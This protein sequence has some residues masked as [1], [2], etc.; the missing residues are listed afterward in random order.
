MSALRDAGYAHVE[1]H[2]RDTMADLLTLASRASAIVVCTGGPAAFV[3][4]PARSTPG[5]VI[6]DVGVPA[7]VRSAQGFTRVTL[8]ELLARPRRLLDDETRAWL[9][10][11]VGTSAEKL[12][13][14]LTDDVAA[15]ALGVIDE[16]RRVFLRET[17]PPLLEKLPHDAAEDVRRACTAFAH[18]LMERVREGGSL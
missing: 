17:L 9:V 13:R 12:S 2:K 14:D 1:G 11:Q 5:A 4:F 15:G 8:E 16:E 7:Q 10:A 3:D 6:V 18:H